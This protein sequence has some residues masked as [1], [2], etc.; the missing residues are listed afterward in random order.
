MGIFP[1]KELKGLALWM[2][3]LADES[4]HLSDYQTV[5]LFDGLPPCG[6][7]SSRV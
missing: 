1:E 3:V 2:R 7:T 6:N 4:C 5:I